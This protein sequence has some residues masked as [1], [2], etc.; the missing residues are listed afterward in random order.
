MIAKVDLRRKDDTQEYPP[1]IKELLEKRGGT[2]GSVEKYAGVSLGLFGKIRGGKEPFSPY[3]QEKIKKALEGNPMPP[4]QTAHLSPKI[5]E[6]CPPAL[7][8]LINFKGSK[9]Q[10]AK[11]LGSSEGTLYSVMNG[12]RDMP[13]VWITRAKTAMG[14]SV[15][16]APHEPIAI[17]IPATPQLPE[18]V[19]W[20]KKTKSVIKTKA[21]GKN[22]GRTIK[23]VPKPMADLVEKYDG[24]INKAAQALGMTGGAFLGW[25]EGKREFTLERQQRIHAALHGLV[26][27]STT[28]SMGEQFDKYDLGIAI[29]MMKGTNFDRI[30]DI[31]EILNAKMV[32]RK[33]TPKGWI[34]IYRMADE[35]LP[36]FKRLALRDAEEIVC[37]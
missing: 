11:A 6:T 30:A 17:A 10:A 14:Q 28:N 22:K 2:I 25:V 19:P 13:P 23:N 37:P 32:F 16:E 33:N 18:F 1:A 34:I 35:D 12:K 24:I 26:P 21:W 20:N 7:A 9:L 29:C 4:K 27:V 15:I 5:P 31:A 3:I 36:K 8:E